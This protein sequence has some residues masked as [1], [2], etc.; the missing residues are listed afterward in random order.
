MGRALL[1]AAEEDIRKRG[2]G[3]IAAWG[4]TLPFFMRSSWFK[5]RGYVT[6]DKNGVM[7]LVWKELIPGSR[8]PRW[9]KPVAPDNPEEGRVVVTSFR[10]GICP[11]MNTVHNRFRR[12]VEEL[13]GKAVLKIIDTSDAENISRWGQTDAVYIN[14]KEFPMGPPPSYKKIL[15]ALKK[16]TKKL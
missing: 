4:M 9:R 2:T 15:K 3:G 8:P 1:L 13:S 10:N 14:G 6:A 12:A 11:A 16:E 5:R 7:E